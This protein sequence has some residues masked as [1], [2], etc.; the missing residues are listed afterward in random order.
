MRTSFFLT[1]SDNKHNENAQ[2]IKY[3]LHRQICNVTIDNAGRQRNIMTSFLWRTKMPPLLEN[4]LSL[5]SFLKMVVL[6]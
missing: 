3:I 4:I 5:I 6:Y 1:L 2:I